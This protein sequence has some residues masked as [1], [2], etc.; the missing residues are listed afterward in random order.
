GSFEMSSFAP[1]DGVVPG[2]YQVAINTQTS[3]PTP[4][5][6]MAPEIWAAPRRYGS[7]DK[8]GLKVTVEAG[9]SGPMEV[10]FDLEK[11]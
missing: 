1:G 3:G 9:S 10:Q 11:K 6:P 8:S 5:N 2:E 4:E 7:S